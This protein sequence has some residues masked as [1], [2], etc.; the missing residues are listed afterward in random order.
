MYSSG[1]YVSIVFC[2][3]AYIFRIPFYLYHLDC[4]PGKAAQ[5][6]SQFVSHQYIL[7]EE[8]KTY[9]AKKSNI[10]LISYPIRY[11]ISEKISLNDAKK[12]LGICLNQKV[13]FILGGSQGSKQIN[14][15]LIYFFDRLNKE[16]PTQLL[17][18]S[19]ELYFIHQSG[20]EDVD[21]IKLLYQSYNVL[22]DVF[23]YKNDLLN[24]YCSSDIIISRAG[25][26][27]LAEIDFFEK[28]SIVIPLQGCA[29]DHQLKN[30]KKFVE[31]NKNSSIVYTENDFYNFFVNILF[32]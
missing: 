10:A 14:D 25:A 16:N 29:G 17:Q 11:S 31:K 19:K 32:S 8:T 27:T 13:I 22:F 2:L 9:I 4:I 26:G 15:F 3:I 7:F 20:S 5:Y 23:D 28:K 21:K 24:F 18:L 1:G 12:R 30:A 6:M